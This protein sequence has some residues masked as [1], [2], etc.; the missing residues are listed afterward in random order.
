MFLL[1]KSYS[2]DRGAKAHGQKF[3]GLACHIG[4]TPAVTGIEFSKRVR[5]KTLDVIHPIEW[6]LWI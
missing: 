2:L 4:A 3:V 6:L 5:T 1:T